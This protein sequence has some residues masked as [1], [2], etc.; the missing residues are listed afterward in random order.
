MLHDSDS[1][2]L[3]EALQYPN[4]EIVIGLELVCV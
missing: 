2:L 3:H 4:L 1:M